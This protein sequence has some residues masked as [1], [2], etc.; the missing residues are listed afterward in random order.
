M[1][2]SYP[3]ARP[4]IR[5]DGGTPMAACSL[6]RA[7]YAFAMP[8]LA[9]TGMRSEPSLGYTRGYSGPSRSES[10]TP[11]PSCTT[12]SRARGVGQR[13]A[14]G[15]RRTRVEQLGP[16]SWRPAGARLPPPADVSVG[17][18][19]SLVFTG[20]PVVGRQRAARRGGGRTSTPLQGGA[21]AA[22]PLSAPAW[23]RAK[24]QGGWLAAQNACGVAGP[25]GKSSP[26]LYVVR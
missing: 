9:R 11:F 3:T 16:A 15:G 8:Y 10:S 17:R 5:A 4:S 26:R 21:S 14:V 23:K 22:S 12:L 7:I 25:L 18:N 1:D 20:A 24:T 19:A 13:R 6:V 2:P